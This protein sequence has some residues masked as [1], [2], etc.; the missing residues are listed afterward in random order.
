MDEGLV[1]LI[2]A[3]IYLSCCTTGPIVRYRGQ[4]MAAIALD[5]ERLHNAPRYHQL[6][7]ISGHF[8]DCDA[9]LVLR[10]LM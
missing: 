10:I 6:M 2:V 7:P 5:S 9:L 8:R 3:V 4:W 1:S